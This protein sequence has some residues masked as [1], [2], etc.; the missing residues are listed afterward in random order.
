MTEDKTD[1]RGLVEEWLKKINEAEKVYA[2]YYELVDE[3]R[4][5][6]KDSKGSKSG[7]YNIFWSSVETLKPFLYFKQPKFYVERSNKNAGKAEKLACEMLENALKWDLEQF[8]FDSVIKYARNDFLISGA[9]I[10]WEQYKPVIETQPDPLDPE[11][12]IAVKTGE[13][14]ESVYL[15]PRY[16]L[17][18]TDR[19]GVWEDVTWIAR[20]IYMDR[21]AAEEEFDEEFSENGG[22]RKDVCI[23]EIWDKTSGKIYWLSRAVA[24]KFLKVSDNL[25]NVNG[26]F[27]CPKPIFATMTN[28]SIIPV[29]DYCMI[30]EMLNELNGINSRM[31]LTMQALKV[32]GAYDN[33]FP[34]L[35]DILSKDV[36]LVAVSD[37]VKLRENGGIRGVVDFAPIEQYVTALEQLA[38]RRQD[39]IASIFDVTG[40]SDI[41]RGSSDGSDTATAVVKK[42][43]FG[44]L[45]NQ[46]RQND[47][48][49]FIRDL[50]RIKAE[51]ICEMF[52]PERLA[53]FLDQDKRQDAAL[54]NQAVNILKTEKLRGMLFSVETDA[55]FNREEESGKT[56]N[57]VKTINEMVTVALSTVSQQPLLLPLYKIMI[58]SVV[59]TL[60]RGRVFET[61]LEKVFAD[62]TAFLEQQQQAQQIQQQQTARQSRRPHRPR[63]E[64]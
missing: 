61:V 17:T 51:I 14:V 40:V 52:D 18:D 53:G 21:E 24:D 25:L 30:R 47:M 39:V 50:L 44:T 34:E 55:V 38:V 43:N 27:P 26:F 20:K 33:A 42:T 4:D 63:Q 7:K 60:P 23:Y 15:D 35:A 2:K 1:E 28:N 59:D 36:T 58:D 46:D 3:T 19:V 12:E 45:R 49:R 62:V 6:Y 32:S 57:A 54:V 16:F 5:F 41:M 8:D 13:K 48:Q 37:F 11:S 64:A 56:I 10:V 9:G 31:K 22:G 29:P